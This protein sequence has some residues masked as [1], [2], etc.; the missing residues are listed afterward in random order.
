MNYRDIINDARILAD[1]SSDNKNSSDSELLSFLNIHL[2]GLYL[3]QIE[4]NTTENKVTVDSIPVFNKDLEKYEID[5]PVDLISV[6]SIT[7]KDTRVDE[8]SAIRY[9]Q[10]NDKFLLE[11]YEQ[12]KLIYTPMYASVTDLDTAM[13]RPELLNAY[14]LIYSIA[15]TLANS[16]DDE[17]KVKYLQSEMKTKNLTMNV[18]GVENVRYVR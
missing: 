8:N 10:L 7:Y 14:Y 18:L 9:T 3:R 12:V 11:S 4:F 17:E 5:I 13:T 1:T 16:A 2:R 15:V 6:I